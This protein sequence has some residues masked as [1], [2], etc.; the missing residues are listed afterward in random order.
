MALQNVLTISQS[1]TKV[2]LFCLFVFSPLPGILLPGMIEYG[3]AHS[4][5]IVLSSSVQEKKAARRKLLEEVERKRRQNYL[6][7]IP[8]FAVCHEIF[9]NIT[10]SHNSHDIMHEMLVLPK[11][12]VHFCK[13]HLY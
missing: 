9:L 13:V 3:F 6:R 11:L 8:H 10:K 4:Q 5:R 7:L 2:S 1:Q 12:E